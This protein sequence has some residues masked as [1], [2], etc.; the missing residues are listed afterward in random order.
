MTLEDIYFIGQTIAVVAIFGSLAY[1]A[2]QTRQNGRLM[3]AKAAWDAQMSFMEINERLASGDAISQLTFK[4]H[5]NEASLTPYEKYLVHRFMRGV[6]QRT[7]AQ[8]ALFQSGILDAEVWSLRINYVKSLMNYPA[9]AE[10]WEAEKKN[11]MFTRAFIAEM[12]RTSST[13]APV[14]MGAG[15]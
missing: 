5:G 10:I 6:L 3:R 1:V 11:S 9:F 15:G 13:S 12:D 2:I 4:V 7:E 8:F 14:F